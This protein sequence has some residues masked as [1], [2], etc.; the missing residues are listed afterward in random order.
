MVQAKVGNNRFV[1]C[2]VYDNQHDTNSGIKKS[3]RPV[4][5]H[6]L[7]IKLGYTNLRCSLNLWIGLEQKDVYVIRGNS[8][9]LDKFA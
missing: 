7:G 6:P 1:V 2:L 8:P 9:C 5:Q 4:L 3:D